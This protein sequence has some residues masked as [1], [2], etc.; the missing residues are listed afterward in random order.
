MEAASNALD[1][2]TDAHRRGPDTILNVTRVLIQ[3]VARILAKGKKR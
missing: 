3:S 2:F 1:W